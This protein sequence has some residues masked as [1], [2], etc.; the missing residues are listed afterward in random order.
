MHFAT[1]WRDLRRTGDQVKGG[2][3]AGQEN[4][5]A[6]QR[7]AM[8]SFARSTWKWNLTLTGSVKSS[9]EGAVANV[10]LSLSALNSA[11]FCRTNAIRTLYKPVT[12]RHLATAAPS[13]P[14]RDLVP[15]ITSVAFASFW[16]TARTQSLRICHLAM[17]RTTTAACPKIDFEPDWCAQL[18]IGLRFP[19]LH[20]PPL[21]LHHAIWLT[22]ERRANTSRF[23]R[24]YW[25]CE[26]PVP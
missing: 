21:E 12:H 8:K 25:Q 1:H 16:R 5:C 11:S 24:Q 20:F 15:T 13:L 6:V 3:G 17:A 18:A 2:R 14:R 22:S 7:S 4:R 26:L 10:A 19:H 23:P 9:G